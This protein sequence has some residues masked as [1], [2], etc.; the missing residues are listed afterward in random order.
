MGKTQEQGWS[1]WSA[2]EAGSQAETSSGGS[3]VVRSSA[4]ERSRTGDPVAGVAAA[5]PP[6]CDAE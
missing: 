3:V 2:D 4:A 6:G 1:C 5:S